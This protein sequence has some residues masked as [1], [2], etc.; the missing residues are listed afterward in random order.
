MNT[1]ATRAKTRLIENRMDYQVLAQRRREEDGPELRDLVRLAEIHRE[2]ARLTAEVYQ[3]VRRRINCDLA[4]N[5][6]HERILSLAKREA[7][8]LEGIANEVA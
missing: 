1:A 5:A 3:I 6:D 4:E 7:Q 2:V 8:L